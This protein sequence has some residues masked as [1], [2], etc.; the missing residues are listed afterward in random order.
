MNPEMDRARLDRNYS[1]LFLDDVSWDDFSTGFTQTVQNIREFSFYAVLSGVGRWSKLID[2]SRVALRLHGAVEEA[3]I[4]AKFANLPLLETAIADERLLFQFRDTDYAFDL[5]F[6]GD[7][8]VQ[9]TRPGSTLRTFHRWYTHF[10]PTIPDIL[11]KAIDAF[12]TE[13]HRTLEGEHVNDASADEIP[14]RV[15]LLTASFTF[16]IVCHNFRRHRHNNHHARNLDVMMENIAIRL[17]DAEGR[18]NRDVGGN[19]LQ[20]S[21]DDFGRMDYRVSRLH[22]TQESVS[23]HLQVMAPSASGWTGLFFHLVYSGEHSGADEHGGRV[24][25][26]AHHFLQ[27]AAGADAYI[28][29]FRDIGLEGF[30]SSVTKGYDFDTTSGSLA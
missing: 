22:P 15:K 1:A 12:D 27:P 16:D 7:G 11:R 4:Q 29:F 28:S 14:R 10:M 18:I 19:P 13:L 23:Q 21:F 17:P 9:L 6:Y 3:L 5:S 24:M 2:S 25:L 8:R 26:D 30:V 20:G